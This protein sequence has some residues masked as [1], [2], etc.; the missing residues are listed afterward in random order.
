MNMPRN[1][2]VNG[3]HNKPETN[4]EAWFKSVEGMHPKGGK[5]VEGDGVLTHGWGHK[6]IEGYNFTG[7]T[8]A[9]WDSLLVDD[10]KK[11]QGR[12]RQQFTNLYGKHNAADSKGNTYS[13]EYEVYD[14]LPQDAKT[15]LTDFSFNLG[16]LV[17][18]DGRGYPKM[19]DALA[20][21]D[22]FTVAKEF[23]RPQ[24]G[25]RNEKM[26]NHFIYP[27]LSPEEKTK[28]GF[29]I[30]QILINSFKGM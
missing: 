26:F 18:P 9:D 5:D 30:E 12:A 28:L 10:I 17:K 29:P 19:V 8:S 7:F 14:N 25:S 21:N 27:N 1:H 16:H 23:K 6:N 3:K 13:T 22:W 15:I 4:L 2:F 24:V 11:A 20:N